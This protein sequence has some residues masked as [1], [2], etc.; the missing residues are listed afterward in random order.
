MSDSTTTRSGVPWRDNWL[1]RYG[2]THNESF[3]PSESDFYCIHGKFH[4]CDLHTIN[5]NDCDKTTGRLQ[6]IDHYEDPWPLV[7]LDSDFVKNPSNL[8]CSSNEDN[9]DVPVFEETIEGNETVSTQSNL[10][11]IASHEHTCVLSTSLSTGIT[12]VRPASLP[13]S[14]SLHENNKCVSESNMTTCSLPRARVSRERSSSSMT[15]TFDEIIRNEIV[16]KENGR[17]PD[18]SCKDLKARKAAVP[19]NGGWKVSALYAVVSSSE[20]IESR[21]KARRCESAKKKPPT[22]RRKS[23]D[24]SSKSEVAAYDTLRRT[25]ELVKNDSVKADCNLKFTAPV[26]CQRLADTCTTDDVENV[27]NG[28]KEDIGYG[29]KQCITEPYKVSKYATGT[30]QFGK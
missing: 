21:N 15:S 22:P 11:N 14:L 12:R 1:V 27:C 13:P 10:E 25:L 26:S 2:S 8:E 30:V 4:N 18:K 20:Q 7:R 6:T 23:S 19:I 28:R 9:E 16:N 29:T 5:I 24:K 3:G 17:D